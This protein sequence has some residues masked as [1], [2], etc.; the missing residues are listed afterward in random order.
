MEQ[1]VLGKRSMARDP[2]VAATWMGA[3]V[4]L[5]CGVWLHFLGG[6]AS[7][8]PA[9]V[10]LEL[11]QELGWIDERLASEGEGQAVV[12][13]QRASRIASLHWDRAS[14]LAQHEYY[15]QCGTS[16]SDDREQDYA[17]FRA[18]CLRRDPSGDV[19]ATL[20]AARRALELARPGP[21]RSRALWFLSL[22]ASATGR[23][24]EQ[25]GA[26]IEMARSKPRQAWVWRLLARAYEARGDRGLQ[27][28]AEEQCWRV[29]SGRVPSAFI[30]RAVR[31]T[32]YAQAPPRPVGIGK[33]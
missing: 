7:P 22:A 2:R 15:R 12:D 24:E 14:R 19:A 20:R 26:L 5:G 8:R 16:W 28:L 23:Q 4:V 3:V 13:P 27:E 18:Q 33:A 21:D 17:R 6:A 25:I 30:C 31:H 11:A 1:R 10:S 32:P 29:G 9:A